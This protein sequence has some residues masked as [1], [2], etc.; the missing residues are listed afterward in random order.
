[1]EASRETIR[2]PL[3]SF[4]SVRGGGGEKFVAVSKCGLKEKK[5]SIVK[6]MQDL[7]FRAGSETRKTQHGP[8][9]T[10]ARRK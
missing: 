4:R 3:L 1:M 10:S 9:E 6:M 8:V 7:P 2:P 5:Q